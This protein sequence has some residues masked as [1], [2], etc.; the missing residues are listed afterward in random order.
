VVTVQNVAGVLQRI[1]RELVQ[2]RADLRDLRSLIEDQPLPSSNSSASQQ[3]V[4][5]VVNGPVSSIAD[6][7]KLVSC[8]ADPSQRN[9]VVFFFN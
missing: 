8:C 5:L 2:L 4:A 7:D 6:Y 3:E 9:Y 1:A